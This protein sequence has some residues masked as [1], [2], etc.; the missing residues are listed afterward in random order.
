MEVRGRDGKRMTD[1]FANG[2]RTFHGF[3]TAGFPNFFMLGLSQNGFKPNVTDMLAEQ[4]EHLSAL[5][6]AAR[7]WGRPASRRREMRSMTG[8]GRSVKTRSAPASVP[9]P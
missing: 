4:A 3:Y 7:S 5:I 6:A 1:H 8:S 9:P 2:M